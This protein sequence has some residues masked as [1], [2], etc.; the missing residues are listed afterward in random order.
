MNVLLISANMETLN[1]PPLPL[2]LACV[3]AATRSAGHEVALINL[4]FEEDAARAIRRPLE[5]FRPDVIGVSV[6]NIDDQSMEQPRSFLD[7]AREV[8]A[9]CRKGCDAPIVL[10][11]AGYSIFPECALRYLG[12]DIGIQGEG[13]AV[14]P[15][16][17]DRMGGGGQLSEIPGVHLPGT[18]PKGRVFRKDLDDLP[19]PEPRLLIPPGVDPET[20]WVPVQ[21]RRGCPM[22]CIFCSTRSIEGGPIRRRSPERIAGW[23]AQMQQ[24]GCR[25]FNFVDNTF[26]LPPHYAKALCR[27]IIRAGVRIRFWS[28]I[29]PKWIDAEL[30]DLMARAGCSQISL[31]FESGSDRILRTLRKRYCP[32]EVETVSKMFRAAGIARMGFLL[33]G[34][35]GETRETVEESLAFADSLHLDAL[36]ITAGIRV[37]PRT[38]LAETA[39]EEGVIGPDDDLLAPR[40]YLAA[41]LREWLPERVAAYSSARA[42]VS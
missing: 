40:F 17:L 31:G 30:V 9:N 19:L 7:A 18:P 16:L 13:E 21:S 27:A 34:G 14:F 29:Y 24:A 1:M 33:L 35:P 20:L 12:A 15:L 10:G 23:L 26:N 3:A 37:Y 39:V 42:W 5:D 11:G 25:N 8:I 28:I 32:E 41:G 38:P 4:M 22:D 6:R 2:G 36:K